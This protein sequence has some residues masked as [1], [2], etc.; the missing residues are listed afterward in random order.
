MV[1]I[2]EAPGDLEDKAGHPFVGPAGA[3]LDEALEAA[4]INRKEIFLTNV[5]K[6]FKR[7]PRGKRR[8][9]A[10]PSSR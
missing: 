1:I 2:G 4:E 5:V 8:L 3:L 9:H 6:H 7:K 10:K